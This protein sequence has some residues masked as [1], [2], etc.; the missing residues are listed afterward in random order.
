MIA[1]LWIPLGV[2]ALVAIAHLRDRAAGP[3]VLEEPP[4]DLH[5]A[6]L[7]YLWSAHRRQ[8]RPRDVYRAQLLHLAQQGVIEIQP[9]GPVSAPKDFEV[10][11][12]RQPDAG[13]DA[14]FVAF[15][16]EGETDQKVALGE[17]SSGAARGQRLAGWLFGLRLQ[18][19]QTVDAESRA[20]G[21]FALMKWGMGFGKAFMGKPFRLGSRWTR[22]ETWAIVALGL[23]AGPGSLS[24]S[25]SPGAALP[26]VTASIIG[27]AAAVAGV[28]LVPPSAPA[29][30]RR[31]LA[32]W[33]AFRRFLRKFSSLPDAPAAAVVIWE[34]YLVYAVALGVA[35]EVEDQVRS[36]AAPSMLSTLWTGG[37]MALAGMQW[38]RAFPVEQMTAWVAQAQPMLQ[39][40][41][42]QFTGGVTWPPQQ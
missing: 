24:F 16:F 4:E 28:F 3:R 11:L 31:R 42:R 20:T 1:Y 25:W 19:Q 40:L 27:A 8:R 35:E 15:L 7:A 21:L 41:Q 37:P 2:A 32:R 9:V 14:D 18:A 33:G 5:P 10:R 36:H 13:P 38:V 12:L 23:V 26:R 39:Q 17:L 34:K 29:G 30:M 22:W 6:V